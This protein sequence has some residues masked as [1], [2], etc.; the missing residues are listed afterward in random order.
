MIQTSLQNLLTPTCPT[1]W[2]STRWRRWTCTWPRCWGE[3][4]RRAATARWRSTWTRSTRRTRWRELTWRKLSPCKK[5]GSRLQFPNNRQHLNFPNQ[6]LESVYNY[7]REKCNVDLQVRK[8]IRNIV[9][10]KCTEVGSVRWGTELELLRYCVVHKYVHTP[11]CAAQVPTSTW[12]TSQCKKTE[13]IGKAILRSDASQPFVSA[14]KTLT[15]PK[16]I[17]IEIEDFFSFQG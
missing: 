12:P 5:T 7:C 15:L 11:I 9:K 13:F 16:K 3:G 10:A 4:R 6:D 1:S 17:E 2:T 14:R 8:F